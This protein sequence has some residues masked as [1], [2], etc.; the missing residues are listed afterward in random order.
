MTKAELE[1]KLAEQIQVN[2]RLNRELKAEQ[3]EN[4]EL[5]RDLNLEKNKSSERKMRLHRLQD[6]VDELTGTVSR[7]SII[8]YHKHSEGYE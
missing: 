3:S 1:K 5:L 4:G 2:E 6:Q 8:L 7:L